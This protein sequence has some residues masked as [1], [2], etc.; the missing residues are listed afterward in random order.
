MQ[1]GHHR[2]STSS[3]IDLLSHIRDKF[4]QINI[5]GFSPRSSS[6]FVTCLATAGVADPD[7]RERALGLDPWRGA[8]F[9]R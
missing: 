9:G 7:F 2:S 8:N 3:G 6:I 5:H 1:G 4:P